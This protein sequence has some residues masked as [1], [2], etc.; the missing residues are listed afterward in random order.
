M[1]D[2]H[3]T[4]GTHSSINDAHNFSKKIGNFVKPLKRV[5]VLAYP[6][7]H[8]DDHKLGDDIQ[9]VQDICVHQ[10]NG[11]NF[12]LNFP[13]T[14]SFNFPCTI[15]VKKRLSKRHKKGALMIDRHFEK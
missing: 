13:C 2:Q 3:I 14:I 6:C 15:R 8:T 4:L 7:S 1:S 12:F 11:C 5:F 9:E 10:Y